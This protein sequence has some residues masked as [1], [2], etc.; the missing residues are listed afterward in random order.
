MLE[1]TD[2]PCLHGWLVQGPFL[3]LALITRSQFSTFNIAC[4]L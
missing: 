2:L 3:G 1:Q 4:Q